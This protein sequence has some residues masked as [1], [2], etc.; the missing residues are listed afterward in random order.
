MRARAQSSLEYTVIIVCVVAAL[1]AMRVYIK[2]GIQGRLKQAADDL[3]QQYEMGKTT[4]TMAL[5]SSSHVITDVTTETTSSNTLLT[6]TN[7]Q[8]DYETERRY[9]G[10]SITP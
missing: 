1:I 3:G 2:G 10:E 8:I 6:I 9:G 5:E 7:T 4:S